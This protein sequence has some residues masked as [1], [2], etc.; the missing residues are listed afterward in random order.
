MH[1]LQSHRITRRRVYC[2][3]I[4]RGSASEHPSLVNAV[5]VERAAGLMVV[6]REGEELA[7][8]APPP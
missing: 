4:A 8:I 6:A 1:L 7:I 3:I 5:R 2:G